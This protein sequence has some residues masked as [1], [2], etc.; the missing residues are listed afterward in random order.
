MTAQSISTKAWLAF[1]IV[2]VVWGT[3]YPGIKIAVTEMPPFYLSGIRHLIAGM[4]L[5]VYFLWRT[6]RIPVLKDHVR[7]AITGVLMVSGGNGLV[8]WAEQS[9]PSALAAIISAV[10]P[11]ITALLGVVM[12]R[13]KVNLLSVVGL[14]TGL[15]GVVLIFYDSIAGLVNRSYL[16]GNSLILCAV[17]AWSFGS[18]FLKRNPIRTPVFEGIGWQMLYGA[19]VNLAISA[20]AEQPMWLWHYSWPVITATMYLVFVGSI[21]GY[22]CFYYLLDH[23][24]AAQASTYSYLNTIVSV[25]IGWLYLKEVIDPVHLVA[26]CVII[27]GALLANRGFRRHRQRQLS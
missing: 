19:A 9:I 17:A 22:I 20:V 14:L 24:P 2:S 1:A 3:T 6:R 5:V 15:S 18:L 26:M 8:C 12:L 25:I 27:F 4:L 11:L 7:L 13:Q 21:V 10:Y 16:F 23:M